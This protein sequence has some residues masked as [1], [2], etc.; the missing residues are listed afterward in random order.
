MSSISGKIVPYVTNPAKKNTHKKEQS[1]PIAIPST[2]IIWQ[3]AI[4]WQIFQNKKM[5]TN[6][7]K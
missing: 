7:K 5:F 2:S 1:S 6:G 4:I 3:K